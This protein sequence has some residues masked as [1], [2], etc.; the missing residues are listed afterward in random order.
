MKEKELREILF[1][2]QLPDPNRPHFGRKT[3]EYVTETIT[4][5]DAST[6]VFPT[7]TETSSSEINLED[8]VLRRGNFAELPAH[9]PKF[10]GEV[11]GPYF[12]ESVFQDLPLD[13]SFDDFV[14]ELD[15]QMSRGPIHFVS[16]VAPIGQSDPSAELSILWACRQL[17]IQGKRSHR[18]FNYNYVHF[19]FIFIFRSDRF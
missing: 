4:S 14:N 1:N 9:T 2:R 17:S 5:T 15:S 13:T 11:W 7:T 12:D 16:G 19:I 18:I 10:L 8:Y 3:A 6:E